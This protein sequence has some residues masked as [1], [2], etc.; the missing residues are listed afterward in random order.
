MSNPRFAIRCGMTLVEL[1]VVVAILGLLAVTVLPAFSSGSDARAARQAVAVVTSQ[2]SKAQAAAIGN[3]LPAGVWI[4]PLGVGAT[5]LELALARQPAPYQGDTFSA[6]VS[7]SAIN[8]GTFALTFSGSH[9]TLL[10]GST[11]PPFV[12]TGD[13]IQ[14]GGSGPV[15]ELVSPT[16]PPQ[17][18]NCSA[19]LRSNA[20]Q[21]PYNTTLP[22]SAVQQ[23]FAIYRRPIRMGG[24][25]T[26]GA[27]MAIDL[28]WSGVGAS[29]FG[30]VSLA[31][32]AG[33][34]SLPGYTPGQA[35]VVLFNAAGALSE[36]HTVNSSPSLSVDQTRLPIREPIFL[37]VGRAD[38]C[39]LPYNPSPTE[40]APG[41][42]WQ[43]PDSYWIAIDPR[44][45]MVKTADTRLAVNNALESRSYI[46]SGLSVPGL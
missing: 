31:G 38:R 7:G 2:L 14:F 24:S 39:G 17:A 9:V 35:I 29:R 13:L 21:T 37:L 33:L 45:G 34:S 22:A 1:L 28:A 16:I 42:N 4:Q 20:G 5:A 46:R 23:S 19:R 11:T 3:P 15:F 43:Y 10:T 40:D 27:G 12:S 36:L 25:A 32:D 8:S 30:Q 41:A 26:I 44:S 18:D 6:T